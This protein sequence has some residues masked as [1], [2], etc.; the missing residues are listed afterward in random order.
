[1]DDGIWSIVYYRALLGRIN[2][3]TGEMTGAMV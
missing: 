1:V 2:E 3:R